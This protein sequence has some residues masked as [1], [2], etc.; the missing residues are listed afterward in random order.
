MKKI[1]F[2]TCAVCLTALHV[3]PI[4]AQDGDAITVSYFSG[5]PLTVC[6]ADIFINTAVYPP[7]ITTTKLPAGKVDVEYAETIAVEGTMPIDWKIIE[8]ALPEG[9][10]LTDDG[11]VSGAPKKAG[12]FTFNGFYPLFFRLYL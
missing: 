10:T 1:L 2:I 12:E 9:L 3:Q 8:G 6:G 7:S 11:A 4:N 5:Y